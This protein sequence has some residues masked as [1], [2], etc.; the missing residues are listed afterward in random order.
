[1]FGEA[2]LPLVEIAGQQI[3]RQGALPLQVEQDR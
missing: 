1:M 2:R 3:N